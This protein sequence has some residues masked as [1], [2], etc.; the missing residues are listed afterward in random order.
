VPAD[1]PV[2]HRAL[3]AYARIADVVVRWTDDGSR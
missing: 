3:T 1:H 2:D